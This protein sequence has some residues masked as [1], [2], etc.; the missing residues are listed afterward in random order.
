MPQ[1]SNPLLTEENKEL[2]KN[3]KHC[4]ILEFVLQR[5]VRQRPDLNGVIVRFHEMFPEAVN[6]ALLKLTMPPPRFAAHSARF[7]QDSSRFDSSRLTIDG[8]GDPSAGNFPSSS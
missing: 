5:S 7:T 1:V 8:M 3:E 4:Q 2:L 6:G